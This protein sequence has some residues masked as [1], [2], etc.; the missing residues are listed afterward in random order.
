MLG[1]VFLAYLNLHFRLMLLEAQFGVLL[2]P[3]GRNLTLA[4]TAKNW[5]W[6]SMMCWIFRA[7]LG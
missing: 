6:W 1:K 2:E 5:R 4:N 3:P 7:L